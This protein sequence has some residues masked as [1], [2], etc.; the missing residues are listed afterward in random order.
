MS[1]GKNTAKYRKFNIDLPDGPLTLYGGTAVLSAL[2]EVTMDMT[3]Y[4]GVR[5]SQVLKAVYEQGR[6]DGRREIIDSFEKV[7]KSVNYLPPGRPKG[8]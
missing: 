1:D 2:D 5:L 4:K 3:I 7:R 6:K 8:R